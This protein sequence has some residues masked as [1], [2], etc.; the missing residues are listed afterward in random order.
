MGRRIRWLGLVL[1]L[2]FAAVLAQL[3]NIQLRKATAINASKTNPR[4]AA[5]T[6]DNQRGLILA[7][8]GKVL[9]QSVKAPKGGCGGYKYRRQYTTGSLF[10]GVVG[11]YSPCYYTAS[12]VEG[13]YTKYLGPHTQKASTLGQLLNPPGPTTDNVTLT[14][15]PTLQADARQAVTSIPD[16]NK[17]AAVVVE[18]VTTGALL[19]DY[20]NPTFTNNALATTTLKK[21]QAAGQA[22]FHTQDHEGFYAYPPMATWDVFAP[23][24]TF[25][26]VTSS[27]VYNLKPSLENFTFPVA[28]CTKKGQIPETKNQICNDATTPTAANPCGGTMV[29]MLPESCDPG[30]ALLGLAIGGT[31]LNKQATS[32]GYDH[33][34]PVDLEPV[35]K[36]N[37]PTPAEL[38]PT[39]TP[40]LPGVA[41]S[42]FGQQDVTASDLQNVMVAEGIANTGNVMTP[43]VMSAIHNSTGGLIE[44]YKPTVYMH[45]ETAAAAKSV[46]KLMQ[47]VVTTPK[48]TAYGVGFPSSMDIAVKTGTAQAGAGNTNTTDWMIG[49]APAYAPKIAISVVV[50]LQARSAS[51]AAIA[52]PIMKTMMADALA[53]VPHDTNAPPTTSTTNTYPSTTA[54][55][56]TTPKTTFPAATGTTSPPTTSTPT[57]TTPT[58]TVP[59]TTTPATATTLGPGGVTNAAAVRGGAPAARRRPAAVRSVRG[60]SAPA[61]SRAPPATGVCDHSSA[62]RRARPRLGRACNR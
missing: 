21:L 58:T 62:R 32:F 17:D 34:P 7:S 46:N 38:A 61:A 59:A 19:A 10:S 23:G 14:I 60:Q 5:L 18:K 22:V 39:G 54:P 51:G 57:T 43:H 42:A 44:K 49:F 13:W 26:V 29:Q 37:F 15:N 25:K 24:S 45:A 28:G 11:Y 20:S 50:P 36:S 35:S 47:S 56:G 31:D 40:G 27:A 1:V 55:P 48:G 6:A 30:Y 9:A 3:V 52:G 12:G 4:N 8:T 33:V 53:A 2:C 41:L 16:S